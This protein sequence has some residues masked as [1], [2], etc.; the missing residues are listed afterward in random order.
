MN[1]QNSA[2]CRS[3]KKAL[4]SHQELFFYRDINGGLHLVIA[5]EDK[6]D[7]VW[8]TGD[9]PSDKN[10]NKTPYKVH[11]LGCKKAI[12]NHVNQFLDHLPY[13]LTLD[14]EE[15]ALT[16]EHLAIKFS[17]QKKWKEVQGRVGNLIPEYSSAT[18]PGAPKIKS[19][20][21]PYKPTELPRDEEHFE[22][23][24]QTVQLVFKPY[25]YQWESTRQ[26][27]PK[28]T[29]VVLPTGKGKT[30]IAVMVMKILYQLNNLKQEEKETYQKRMIL[31]LTN[32]IPLAEQQAKAIKQDCPDLKIHLRTGEGESGNI[33]EDRQYDVIVCTADIIRNWIGYNMASMK[34]FYLVI[35]DECHHATGEHVFVKLAEEIKKLDREFQPRILGLTASPST[36]G[37]DT[38]QIMKNIDALE[39]NIGSTIFRPKSLPMENPLEMES[40]VYQFTRQ[41]I[42]T[43]K[44]IDSVLA[45]ATKRLCDELKFTDPNLRYNDQNYTSFYQGLKKLDDYHRD[46]N[47]PRMTSVPSGLLYKLFNL[48][49]ILQ[50]QGIQA[51]LT[52]IV[53]DLQMDELDSY[54]TSAYM[55]YM[56]KI[57]KGVLDQFV[58]TN[59]PLYS[60]K[61]KALRD[62]I[63]NFIEKSV[64]NDTISD[65][66]G[67]VFVKTRQGCSD[68]IKLLKKEPVNLHIKS[69]LFVGHTGED[70]MS[71]EKQNRIM[72]SFRKG[73]CK[74]L[75]ATSVL[76][77]GIDV[78]QCN[79]VISFDPDL[80][81]RNMIQ[82]RGRARS[83]DGKFAY[84]IK[85][86][87][88][89]EI[90]SL[91]KNEIL[92]A[93]IILE[94]MDVRKSEY[95]NSIKQYKF[96]DGSYS[97]DRAH[98]SLVL[99]FYHYDED[100]LQERLKSLEPKSIEEVYSKKEKRRY[101]NQY[102]LVGM[103]TNTQSFEDLFKSVALAPSEQ[104]PSSDVASN[105]P[106]YFWGA[107]VNI[108]EKHSISGSDKTDSYFS[109]ANIKVG[110]FSTPTCF[111][112]SKEY[113]YS[114][115]KVD[116]T[117]RKVT[118][119]TKDPMLTIGTI[120]HEIYFE[121]LDDFLLYDVIKKVF[122][123]ILKRPPKFIAKT[124][125]DADPMNL[126]EQFYVDWNGPARV[127]Y[128]YM[129]PTDYVEIGALKDCYAYQIE[130]I[131][132]LDIE[133]MYYGWEEE[134]PTDTIPFEKLISRKLKS[135]FLYYCSILEDDTHQD[136]DGSHHLSDLRKPLSQDHYYLLNVLKSNKEFGK[137]LIDSKFYENMDLVKGKENRYEY[138]MRAIDSAPFDNRFYQIDRIG[139]VNLNSPLDSLQATR[140][141]YAL[142]KNVYITPTRTLFQKPS[143][144]QLNRALRRYGA[145]NFLLVHFVE[146]NLDEK[147]EYSKFQTKSIENIL[148]EGIMIEG[149][150][151]FH[152]IGNSASQ[153]RSSSCWFTNNRNDIDTIRNQLVDLSINTGIA[154]P[155][156]YLRSLGLVFSGT[157]P[158]IIIPNNQYNEN[159]D[160][161][162][163]DEAIFTEGIGFIGK[164]LANKINAE[165]SF[166]LG[167]SSYQI[168]IG[169]N[170]GVVSVHHSIEN[171][172]Y[173]RN[174]MKKFN[175]NN[176]EMNR[177]LEIISIAS[178]KNCTL[179]RQIINLFGGLGVPD[180]L[181]L[182]LVMECLEKLALILQDSSMARSELKN[183]DFFNQSEPTE[184][185]LLY[186]PLIRRI[187]HT[188]YKKQ[189]TKY[190]D[191]C[192]IPIKNARTL[193]GVI[194][195]T[196]TLEENQVFVR[197]TA[198]NNEIIVIQSN[199]AVVKNPCLHPGDV[200]LA[201]G[202]DNQLLHHMLDVVVFS[203]KGT[204][205]LFSK[206]SGS[207]LDG[208]RYFVCFD[209]DMV[210][211]IV[212]HKDFCNLPS[213]SDSTVKEINK[214]TVIQQFIE[215]TQKGRLGQ[216]ALSHLAI[217]DYKSPTD[218]LAIELA[219][220]H[221]KE[222][223]FVK[224]NIHG[225]VPEQALEL[226]NYGR[227]YPMF[228]KASV[229]ANK[230]FSESTK[231]LGKIYN[232]CSSLV[233]VAQYLPDSRVDESI[234]VSGYE[235]YVEDARHQFKNYKKEIRYLRSKYNIE[236]E[237]DIISSYMDNS[238][239]GSS[240]SKNIVEDAYNQFSVLAVHYRDL[241]LLPFKSK[242]SGGGVSDEDI[243]IKYRQE[244]DKKVSAWY[245]VSYG[246]D[247]LEK[248][249]SFY[250]IVKR[251][252]NLNSERYQVDRNL[253][254]KDIISN[255]L[256]NQCELFSSFATRC[257]I[258]KSVISG[259]KKYCPEYFSEANLLLYGSSSFFLHSPT[260]SDI[261]IYLYT[262]HG[263]ALTNDDIFK[264]VELVLRSNDID[265]EHIEYIEKT[266]VPIVTFTSN[267]ISCDISLDSNGFD[268]TNYVCSYIDKYPFL[269]PF[270][271]T[272]VSWGRETG[273]L[274]H[275]VTDIKTR[276]LKTW[277]LVWMVIEYCLKK[278]IIQKMEPVF[279]TNDSPFSKLEWWTNI[280]RIISNDVDNSI[281]QVIG[282]YVLDFFK[283][284][285]KELS[286][287][288]F[289]AT[290]YKLVCPLDRVDLPSLLLEPVY[291]NYHFLQE[292]FQLAFHSLS[293]KGGSITEF[294]KHCHNKNSKVIYLDRLLVH[295]LRGGD[296]MS[297]FENNL[298]VKTGATN[299]DIR[300]IKGNRYQMKISGD[301]ESIQMVIE[302]V[303][304]LS[305]NISTTPFS[306][307]KKIVTG[308]GTT[309]LMEGSE[310]NGNTI[311]FVNSTRRV[312]VQHLGKRP[313]F[314]ML[315]VPNQNI[316]ILDDAHMEYTNTIYRQLERFYYFGEAAVHWGDTQAHIRFGQI[317]FINVSHSGCEKTLAETRLGMS[318]GSKETVKFEL[319]GN[320]VI[321]QDHIKKVKESKKKDLSD[322][323]GQ[324]SG[325]IV[326]T[327]S[328]AFVDRG[329]EDE[330]KQSNKT[331]E[332]KSSFFTFVLDSVRSMEDLLLGEG[333][334]LRDKPHK[335]PLVIHMTLNTL[336]RLKK[337][338]EY[339]IRVSKDFKKIVMQNPTLT[340]FGSDLKSRNDEHFDLRYSIQ[341]RKAYPKIFVG[342]EESCK[343]EWIKKQP[344]MDAHLLGKLLITP[345][346]VNTLT[347]YEVHPEIKENIVLIREHTNNRTY[348]PPAGHPLAYYNISATLTEIQ[349]FD[350]SGKILT[351][352]TELEFS[353][354]LPRQ[355]DTALFV[356]PYWQ[357]GIDFLN[358]LNKKKDDID[359]DCHD[360]K[361]Q[362][363]E[364]GN[365][366]CFK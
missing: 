155:R 29:I 261:D 139:K 61:Y 299:V 156:K 77:E 108:H 182:M 3:C 130:F 133:D 315:K 195:E 322:S 58:G 258:L 44:E 273:L 62:Y 17:K 311:I 230:E 90:K 82:R 72:E 214:D 24:C 362:H 129:L 253:L 40:I 21:K 102:L 307:T 35:Y 1:I 292:T 205:P 172:I 131:E 160:D 161:V 366:H 272:V 346:R 318:K 169:G 93:K 42:G 316:G 365:D 224:T 8:Y 70:G 241:F 221:F 49:G 74:F 63:N 64:A 170:K 4:F 43:R 183:I 118:I 153:A 347:K 296:D 267:G 19:S 11:C 185:E 80:N 86:G 136:D 326:D 22:E 228:M 252:I 180:R 290:Q 344:Y 83:K 56:K 363:Y 162:R 33:M 146:E 265:V 13:V 151:R 234:L 119:G 339:K 113:P 26:S 116:P 101:L 106:C 236:K 295:R 319:S 168:R 89:D 310:T 149:I 41:E 271:Y 342:D 275:Q 124:I 297:F 158:S 336:D 9:N 55:Y 277:A 217:S 51:V 127:S 203:Q 128:R 306:S 243:V 143:M 320:V 338:T 88:T 30:K 34:D 231:V 78:Q 79:M 50:V 2:F 47:P 232:Q 189:L 152:Y 219:I 220:E 216:I 122:Y 343:A 335:S 215:N 45:E 97:L 94:Y 187:L 75:V 54:Y 279:Y 10:R 134:Q 16:H 92:M 309:L 154:N 225:T 357:Q 327:A 358:L 337:K 140:E 248:V 165:N 227:R 262:N 332:P 59:P 266:A 98:H 31:F 340:W 39:R 73:D 293:S 68:L 112:P 71:T 226:T 115:F 305:N 254:S 100:L 164:N 235:D 280:F 233:S 147:V 194:D 313:S 197:I 283:F 65:V 110:N 198:D 269:Y 284:Y 255:V 157:T 287:G 57:Q 104:D 330:E 178:K 264:K 247:K 138:L 126:F 107:A 145:D 359:S 123:I 356:T 246:D 350:K 85:E 312:H 239:S 333:W 144:Y 212:Q 289:N 14:S 237:E 321:K 308:G 121:D 238:M 84:L 150:G 117:Q 242:E 28:N 199:V 251:Y 348:V 5:N 341:S 76:E 351:K 288:Y 210:N 352:K 328:V 167:T 159:L 204:I 181:F 200:Q 87:E 109:R 120:Y 163:N 99:S 324:P 105:N 268:K 349:E 186:D 209:T 184:K 218:D 141:N 285:T 60:S 345:N 142:I 111:V 12:G 300:H 263:S 291:P 325:P 270:L 166:P 132:E 250:W 176:S 48:I 137:T 286:F 244:I 302:E 222:V 201:M 32:K 257:Q 207:D 260:Q 114:S 190:L 276:N 18:L 23:I 317:Y 223:D 25:D 36:G 353:M 52:S 37:K 334:T 314:P 67:I 103:E 66:R 148:L 249:L 323:D 38:S 27:V 256:K 355:V 174:S 95:E 46:Q 331:S 171:G 15:V 196:G 240:Y 173:L 298:K 125:D 360:N 274:I 361:R 135:T 7:K 91:E 229:G 211:T 69:K 188:L 192:F 304:N 53:E 329:N 245:F 294:F 6:R 213:K 208:D 202:V 20:N 206:C 81:L 177:T 278:N 354:N 301:P 179:N 96:I 191:F 259:L 175:T 193:L 364:V 282:K 281:E 303:A